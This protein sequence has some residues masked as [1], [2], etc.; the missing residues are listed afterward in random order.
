VVLCPASGT[1][2]ALLAGTCTPSADDG[3]ACSI[4]DTGTHCM[5]PAVC[6]GGTCNL[7]SQSACL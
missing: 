1:C 4:S 6:S 7:L 5:P 2:S 3:A